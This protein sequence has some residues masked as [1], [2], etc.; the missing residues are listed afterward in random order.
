MFVGF[1]DIYIYIPTQADRPIWAQ[2]FTI[3]EIKQWKRKVMNLSKLLQMIEQLLWKIKILLVQ[4]VA[5]MREVFARESMQLKHG[6]FQVQFCRIN[7]DKRTS[8][9]HKCH[10][11]QVLHM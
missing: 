10:L 9:M 4:L 1:E 5:N 7:N 8:S 2:I 11:C 6:L 3:L